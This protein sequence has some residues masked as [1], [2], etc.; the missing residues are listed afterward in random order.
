MT[1]SIGAGDDATTNFDGTV[2]AVDNLHVCG[3]SG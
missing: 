3:S 2:F 1:L